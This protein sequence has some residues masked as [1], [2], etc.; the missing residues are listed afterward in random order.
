MQLRSE[1]TVLRA[2]GA[3][4][5]PDPIVASKD[6]IAE[7][8]VVADGPRSGQTFDMGLT[9]YMPG[10]LDALDDEAVNVVAV[11]KSAQVAFT[12][13]AIGWLMSNIANVPANDMLIQPTIAA[14]QD[15]NR[16][17][18]SPAIE[19]SADLKRRVARQVSR[20]SEGSTA[21]VKIFPGG[22]LILTGANSAADLRSKTTK[23]QVRDE[24][25]EYPA[26]LDGQGDP[27]EML[28]ARLTSFHAT[29]DWK[30]LKGSTPTIKG[31]SRIDKAFED[32]DQRFWHVRCPECGHEQVLRFGDKTSRF[33]LKFNQGFPFDAHYVCEANGCIIEHHQKAD[34]VRAGRWVA[35]NPGP[36]RYPSFH[37]DALISLLTTWDNI[38]QRF[39]NA[40]DDP[41]KLKGFVN[42]VLGQSWE[43]RGEAPDWQKLILR[44]EP[45]LPKTIPLGGLMVTAGCDVQLDG[46]YFEVVSWGVDK[47]SWS[48]EA[49]YLQ[50]DP[51]DIRNP[52][53]RAL[54]EV[55]DRTYPDQNGGDWPIDVAGIDSGYNT[56]VVYD[57]CRRHPRRRATK[58]D[59][60]WYV[61]A[62]SKAPQK[63]QVSFDGKRVGVQLWHIGTWPLKSELYANLRKEGLRDGAEGFPPGYCHF[64][65]A[66]HDE[67]FF[68]Q[69]TAEHMKQEMRSGKI[70]HRW[71]ES[72]PNHWLDCRIIN[73]AMAAHLGID[74][75]TQADWEGLIAARG[76]KDEAQ[77]D[78]FASALSGAAKPKQAIAAGPR[79][80]RFRRR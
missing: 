68:R 34:M 39:L 51:S 78:M 13:T 42:L 44:R 70:Q 56:N 33:G 53:W 21:L 65:E 12:Q 2:W 41:I 46:I 6:W 80:R 54:E 48:I 32:G 11:R 30:V 58:G 45:Y 8:L 18:L 27:E 26:D 67:G 49:G 61:P 15:F 17:K 16:L 71:V 28:D 23:R 35:L 62:I 19:A 43:E 22:S 74:G 24:I 36:G 73:R 47:Q 75:M 79:M 77:R 50:G 4:I 9:P 66:G 55:L 1:A 31:A 76:P 20:S 40:K 25:D 72:G 29:G 60:G 3:A 69:L 37:I 5:A 38:A 7:N 14:A 57:F 52:V 63:Q 59:D 10:I 64:S